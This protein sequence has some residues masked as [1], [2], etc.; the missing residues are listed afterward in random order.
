MG[1]RP[2]EQS[3]LG[4]RVE[5]KATHVTQTPVELAAFF[6][7]AHNTLVFMKLKHDVVY[8][9]EKMLIGEIEFS[10][11]STV[12]IA[13]QAILVGPLEVGRDVF[14]G[15]SSIVG[16]AAD[17]AR[18]RPSNLPQLLW[19]NSQQGGI[20][21]RTI[22]GDG[23]IVRELCVIH[24]GGDS[25]KS[26]KLGD[27]VF[28]HSRCG[29]SHGSSLEENVTLGPNVTVA[30]EAHIGANTTLGANCVINQNLV[31]GPYCVI[32]S[33]SVLTKNLPPLALAKGVPARIAGVNRVLLQR[34]GIAE[35]L[36]AKL[37]QS[38]LDA[39]FFTFAKLL[40]P[41]IKD[42]ILRHSELFGWN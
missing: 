2:L 34:R 9:M 23:V 5:E 27:N 8:H 16:V 21:N 6:S 35:D 40:P 13:P 39:D 11:A 7:V 24:S 12:L 38:L 33:G 14:I 20:A 32:G 22:L 15:M 37:N 30:G 4:P 36:I 17:C 10:D 31:V 29:L 3:K 1:G 19:Q 25:K 41:T 26:T 18:P 42:Q 28:L